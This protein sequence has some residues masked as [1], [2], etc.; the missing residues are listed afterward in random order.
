MG[1]G[2]RATQHPYLPGGYDRRKMPLLSV[3]SPEIWQPVRL[4]PG[5]DPSPLL[6]NHLRCKLVTFLGQPTQ[7]VSNGASK[8]LQQFASDVRTGLDL[9]WLFLMSVEGVALADRLHIL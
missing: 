8:L 7:E 4:T 6:R 3:P 2:L 5:S 9:P 1:L